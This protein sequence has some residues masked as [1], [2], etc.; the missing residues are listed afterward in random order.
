VEQVHGTTIHNISIQKTGSDKHHI[1]RHTFDTK[2]H[3]DILH[4]DTEFDNSATSMKGLYDS[5]HIRVLSYNIWNLNPPWD[6]RL[7]LIST[8]VE[9]INPDLI[10]FQEVRF[11]YEF[12][13]RS[14]ISYQMED[15]VLK[16]NAN[17]HE[18]QYVYQPSMTYLNKM[19]PYS[20][21]TDEGLGIMAK[22][23][24]IQT[25]YVKLTRNFSDFEDGTNNI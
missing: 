13:A 2:S 11:Q 18:Y 21:R 16:L 5:Q 22:Y 4:V 10:A 15:L 6:E 19:N 24:I 17:K 25:D 7:N 1:T 14:T 20:G 3:A 8:Q 9:D 12:S 23:P